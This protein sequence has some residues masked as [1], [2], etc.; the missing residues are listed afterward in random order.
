[1]A[2]FVL[3][4]NAF[5]STISSCL[6]HTARPNRHPSHNSWGLGHPVTLILRWHPETGEGGQIRS[7]RLS[8]SPV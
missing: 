8:P 4:H 3:V 2:T 6:V 1:M 7:L 5:G